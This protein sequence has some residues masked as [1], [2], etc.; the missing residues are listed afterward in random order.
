MRENAENVFF[1]RDFVLLHFC[2]WGKHHQGVSLQRHDQFKLQKKN[3]IKL[4]ILFYIC[5]IFFQSLREMFS[6]SHFMASIRYHR[7]ILII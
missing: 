5:H 6:F 1:I 4:H 7:R 2:F 3:Y